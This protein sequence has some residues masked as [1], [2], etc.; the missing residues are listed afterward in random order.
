MF[1]SFFI[2]LVF[3]LGLAIPGPVQAVTPE[4]ADRS[5]EALNKV[6]WNSSGKYFY[7][8]DN[9]TGVLDFW[10]TAHA[11][12]TV[13]DAYVRTGRADYKQQIKNVY[14]GFIARHT[15]DWTRNDYNDDIAWWVIATARAHGVTGEARYLSQAKS[16]FDW[17]YNTQRDTV[18]GGIWWK[19]NE[20][21]V[22]N[23]CVVQ[24]M[25]ISAMF[26]SRY[27]KDPAYQVKAESLY[28][29]QRRTL[30]DPA[31]GRVY[32]KIDNSGIRSN[33]ASTYNQGTWIGS[34]VLLN[35]IADA[36]RGADYARA[37]LTVSGGILKNEGQGDFGVFKLIFVR[38]TVALSSLPGNETYGQWMETNAAKAWA[39]RRADGVMGTD[40]ANRTPA[41]GVQC[42]SAAAAVALLNLLAT[43]TVSI[44]PRDPGSGKQP[45][46]TVAGPIPGVIPQDGK[47]A[48]SWL[49]SR[50]INGIRSGSPSRLDGRMQPG[51]FMPWRDS[52]FFLPARK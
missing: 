40:W 43:P 26:L 9:K 51:L 42:Q 4:Q 6:F 25:I 16:M 2:G 8:N 50:D 11:W 41:T 20:H 34:G 21:L 49:F 27:L 52:R 13:M 23:S 1:K 44:N 39:N 30:V 19:N 38:Y 18:K 45:G 32:D 33:Y 10:L 31:S 15:A 29:W 17:V 14:D 36:R 35:R 46:S 12:E 3:G 48:A 24:P 28:A 7:K 47:T 5:M 37:N 22:K